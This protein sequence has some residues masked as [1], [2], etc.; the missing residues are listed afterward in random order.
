MLEASWKVYEECAR[1]LGVHG[2]YNLPS[3]YDTEAK[4]DILEAIK[5]PL[6]MQCKIARDP[7]INHLS[8]VYLYS[9]LYA[10]PIVDAY[11]HACKE[12]LAGKGLYFLFISKYAYRI[13]MLCMIQ[14]ITI[15][16]KTLH[17]C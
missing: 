12:N 11:W 8:D 7:Q 9:F 13:V 1:G 10:I 3:C 4:W 14:S 6:S 17:T 15:K 2:S 16:C 5:Y